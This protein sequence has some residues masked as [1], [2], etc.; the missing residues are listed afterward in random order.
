MKKLLCFLYFGLTCLIYTNAQEGLFVGYNTKQAFDFFLTNKSGTELLDASLVSEKIE[1]SPYLNDEFIEGNVYTTSKTRFVDVPLRYNIYNDQVEFRNADDQVLAIATPEIIELVE[2]G[3]FRMEYIPFLNGKK[4]LNG[5]FLVLEKGE[6]SLYV[7]SNVILEQAKQ[8]VAYQDAQPASFIRRSDEFYIKIGK[9]AAKPASKKKDLQE[10][11][12]D[13]DS[14]IS[15]YLK[16][17]KVRPDNLESLK[18][19]VIH[20]NSL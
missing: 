7:K 11:F 4:I 8:A 20:Y 13:M 19:L 1:G 18:E 17:N 14:S 10:I 2:F 3:E 6:A 12:T 9:E 16:N 15:A 5:Y